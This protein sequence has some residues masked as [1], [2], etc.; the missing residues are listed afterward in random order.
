MTAARFSTTP[1]SASGGMLMA[2]G[3]SCG[4]REPQAAAAA[5]AAEALLALAAFWA[6]QLLLLCVDSTSVLSLRGAQN[7]RCGNKSEARRRQAAINKCTDK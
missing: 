5:E 7:K 3:T 1:Y 4:A 2:S 6:L